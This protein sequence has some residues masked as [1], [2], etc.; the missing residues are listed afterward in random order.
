MP[1]TIT[2]EGAM[3][4][5]SCLTVLKDGRV[6]DLY[7]TDACDFTYKVFDIQSSPVW[8]RMFQPQRIFR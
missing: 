6:A 5:Y 3:F 2:A 1:K 7:E 4:A 8:M